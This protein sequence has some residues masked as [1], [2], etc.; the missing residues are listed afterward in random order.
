MRGAFE[1]AIHRHE[2][3]TAQSG[4]AHASLKFSCADS[5]RTYY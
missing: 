5:S 2:I 3:G 1:M 4:I